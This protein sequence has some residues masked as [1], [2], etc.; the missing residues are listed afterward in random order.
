MSLAHRQKAL[1]FASLA[2]LFSV[3]GGMVGY[4]IGA[5]LWNEVGKTVIH[6]FGY[7]EAY[8]AF[9]QLYE[10]NGLIIVLVGAL[11]PFPFKI[12]A[13]LSGAIGYPFSIFMF[14]AAT[15]RGLRFYTIASIIYIWGDQINYFLTKYL[16]LVFAAITTLLIGAFWYLK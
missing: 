13:I 12:V 1:F 14:A 9:T 3:L 16:S 8:S 5:L 15:S 4:L 7:N 11:T 6:Y 2:T 10:E